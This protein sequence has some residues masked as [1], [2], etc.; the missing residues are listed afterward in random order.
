MSDESSGEE[1]TCLQTL[2][3]SGKSQER[4]SSTE[5]TDYLEKKYEIKFV[6]LTGSKEVL[7]TRMFNR[8]GHFM[9]A[10]LL[11]SQLDTLET[12]DKNEN[13]VTV[14]IDKSVEDIVKEIVDKLGL[15]RK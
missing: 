15:L 7:E 9:P 10:K 6:H 3:T 12:L 14:D 1:Q 8:L 11:E 5:N 2:E 13:G 4:F